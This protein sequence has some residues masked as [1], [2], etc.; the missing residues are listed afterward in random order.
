MNASRGPIHKNVDLKRKLYKCNASI[1]FNRQYLKQHITPSYANIRI[2][3]TSLAHKYTQRKIPTIR[4]TDEIRY[5]HA[6]K[7]QL[8][9]QIYHL[10]ISLANTRNMW[11]LLQQN[12]KEKLRT[13]SRTKY[14][15]LGS[16]IKRLTRTQTKTPQEP[17]TF[18]TLIINN[19]NISF[20]NSEITL[21]QKGMKYN[22]HSKKRNWIQNLALEAEIAITQLPSTER[23]V[24]RKLVADRINTLIMQNPTHQTQPETKVIRSIQ[25]KL[26]ENNATVTRADKGNSTVILPT[27][28]YETKIQ[29]FILNNKFRTAT[30]DPT[31]TFQ[32]QVRQT[33]RD[34]KSLIPND[35]RWRYTNMR[36]TS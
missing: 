9:I 21:L 14:K 27:L 16:K 1:Y 28:Q 32:A 29:N 4:I 7:Q 33:I 25:S 26:K 24:Y 20:I 34:S 15:T 8:N 18:Y 22:T 2:P 19:S 12:I 11:P 6:K 5:L 17:H 23:E 3:N 35:T 31:N 30:A 13:E 36:M 10:H